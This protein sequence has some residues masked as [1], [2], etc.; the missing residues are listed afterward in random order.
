MSLGE[1]SGPPGNIIER[2]AQ[3]IRRIILLHLGDNSTEIWGYMLRKHIID[4]ICQIF[5]RS[6]PLLENRKVANVDFMFLI[7]M[8]FRSKIWEIL[9][10]QLA[11]FPGPHLHK[12]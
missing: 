10:N 11:L 7:D 6:A 5:L 4:L 12:I 3:K 9:F 8:K 2:I 1:T